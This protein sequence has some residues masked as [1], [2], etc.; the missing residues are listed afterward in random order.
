MLAVVHSKKEDVMAGHFE[1]ENRPDGQFVF[2]LK[3]GSEAII[4]SEAYT[5]K[6]A[7]MH[8][9]ESVKKNASD[10]GRYRRTST[11]DGRFRFALDAANGEAI[12]ASK[13]YETAGERDDGIGFVMKNA[14]DA[15]V[16]DLT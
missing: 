7:C 14:A 5:T 16:K 15:E 12:G 2:H 3:V 1:V 11:P 13:Y 4:T 10:E 9:I 6:A 8:G